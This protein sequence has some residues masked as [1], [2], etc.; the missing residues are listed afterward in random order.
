M[1]EGFVKLE[2]FQDRGAVRLAAL[3]AS[4][5]DILN[6]LEPTGETHYAGESRAQ[7]SSGPGGRDTAA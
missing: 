1:P 2:S 7:T 5:G 4:P 6:R 3:S